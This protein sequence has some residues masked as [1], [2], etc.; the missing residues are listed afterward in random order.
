MWVAVYC[1][2]SVDPTERG[3]SVT[4]QERNGRRFAA[5]HFPDLPVRVYVDND[6]SAANPAVTR[7]AYQ[8]LVHDV[9]AGNVAAL[10]VRE[11]SRLTRQPSE[12][13]ALCT[14]LQVAGIDV[15]HMTEGGPLSVT[16][17]SRLPGR[18]MAV[19][20]AEYVEQVRAKVKSSLAEN[21]SDGRPHARAGYGYQSIVGDDG[22]PARIP[23]PD[24]APLVADMVQAIADGDSLGIVA[25]RLNLAGVPTPRG[26][27]RWQRATVRTIVTSQRIIGKRSHRGRIT[28]AQWEPIVD[29]V[30]WERAQARLALAKPG[31]TRD[32]RRSYLLTGGLVACATCGS[33]LISATSP[34]ATGTAPSYKCPH[35]SRVPGACGKCSILADRL[36]DHVTGLI[37]AYLD[38]PVTVDALNERLRASSVDTRPI[39]AE[40]EHI[41]GLMADLAVR[42]ANEEVIE[43]EYAAERRTYAERRQALLGQLAHA[44]VE[45]ITLETLLAAWEHGGISRRPIIPLLVETPILVRGAFHGGRRLSV[46]DRITVIFRD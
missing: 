43:V 34:T 25:E 20:D 7:P 35:H 31:T 46:E 13:E 32:L 33:A 19:V 3:V 41:E 37:A 2:K 28:Q 4:V 8:Q 30:T 39:H 9:R 23:D 12:W 42:H 14:T 44:P 1:R 16:E 24:T 11:Q 22:R 10:V 29:R 15:V 27:G 5:K 17:G 6:L 21:A 36:E 26:A 38:D 45:E 18:I 40:L